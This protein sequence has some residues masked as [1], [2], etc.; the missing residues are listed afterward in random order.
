MYPVGVEV[1]N[2]SESPKQ[3]KVHDCCNTA[4]VGES[5]WVLVA[6]TQLQRGWVATHA[7]SVIRVA[8]LSL[9]GTMQLDDVDRGFPNPWANRVCG[10]IC[11]HREGPSA[12]KEHEGKF[13]CAAAFY[14]EVHEELEVGRQVRAM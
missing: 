14:H 2:M 5:A 13:S 6:T 9:Q 1:L 8:D 4:L 7:L 12:A 11:F 10:G 3:R